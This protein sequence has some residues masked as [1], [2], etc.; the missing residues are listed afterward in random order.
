M[1]RRQPEKRWDPP[2]EQRSTTEYVEA[3]RVPNCHVLKRFASYVW[4]RNRGWEENSARISTALVALV[5]IA[6][7]ILD[8]FGVVTLE[9]DWFLRFLVLAAGI[10]L[11]N[12]LVEAKERRAAHIELSTA[13]TA[14]DAASHT[15]AAAVSPA[16]ARQIPGAAIADALAGILGNSSGWLFR[17]GSARYQRAAV[18]PHLAK[19]TA[20]EVPYQI[21]IVDPTNI[22]LCD[23]YAEY[24]RHAR[25]PGTQLP[26]EDADAIRVE[27]LATLYAAGWYRNNSRIRPKVALINSY[28]PIRIDIGAEGAVLT[29]ADRRE[30]GLLI[31][32][33]CPLYLALKDEIEQAAAVLPRV[34]IPSAA[35]L[36]PP[37][38]EQIDAAVVEAAL[39]AMM[40]TPPGN[41]NA[42][43]LIGT[44]SDPDFA[45]VAA[46][47]FAPM[48]Y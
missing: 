13:S 18:L 47:V 43:P 31:P 38:K 32:K 9:S 41:G 44:N 28:S 21:L 42:S 10:A 25:P 36:Y 35:H 37:S 19:V 22:P 33:A 1:Y 48:S 3:A 27:I 45:E 7:P 39:R 30:P 17:G 24:R 8:L 23:A 12:L 4:L 26:D 16:S 5:G 6:S 40:V 2:R 46:R 20:I 34:E 14:M 15:F 11:L 29:V